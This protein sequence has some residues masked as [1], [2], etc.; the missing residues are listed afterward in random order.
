MRGGPP[1]GPPRSFSDPASTFTQSD[2]RRAVVFLVAIKVVGIIL[3]FDPSGLQAFDLPKSLLS[4]ATSVLLATALL[5]LLMRFGYSVIPRTPLH[6]AVAGFVAANLI[7]AAFAQ[8]KYI[9][10]F[11]DQNRYLGL[12]FIADMVVLYVA[13]SVAFLA[14]REWG[15]LLAAAGSAAALSAGYAAVQTLGLDPVRWALD[16]GGRPFST[17]GHPDVLGHFLSIAFGVSVG[18]ALGLRGNRA[19]LLKLGVFATALGCVA[20]AGVVATRGTLLGI[21]GAL[22]VAT[23]ILLRSHVGMRIPL[24]Q[25]TVGGLLVLGAL[26]AV[27]EFTP[28]GARTSQMFTD[29]GSGRVSLYEAAVHAALSRPIVGFGPDNFG[30]AFPAYREPPPDG[31]TDPQTSA[32]D[33]ILQAAV[34]TGV[35]GLSSLIALLAVA[36]VLLWRTAIPRA[37]AIGLPL[38]LGLAAYWTH[39]VVAVGSISVDW[40]PWLCFGSI[41]SL[42]GV[43]RPT[44]T[45]QI[46]RLLGAVVLGVGLV[47]ATLP[48]QA[49]QANRDAGLARLHWAAGDP[50]VA[51]A[52]A[53]S[54]TARDS[55]RAEYWN[56]LGLA[57]SKAGLA[58]DA[59][60]AFEEAARR[61]PHEATYWLN[62]SLARERQALNG[63][64]ADRAARFAVAAAQRAVEVDPYAP[65]VNENLADVALRMG[66]FDVALRAGV[67]TALIYDGYPT[68][69]H[70]AYVAAP[71]VSDLPG[72]RAVL[73]RAVKIR[74][75]AELHAALGRVALL[76]GDRE[77]ARASARRAL[78]LEP[79]NSEARELILEL[80]DAN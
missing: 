13:T 75:T 41:A 33:W 72:A 6:F 1:N 39:A 4:G 49:Y 22:A 52:L 7:S 32:H 53:E 43:R 68:Y 29:A 11:G 2:L 76:M 44:P 63:E 78:E 70:V 3:I 58:A 45:R 24:R 54:A 74:D 46:P 27:V 57:R 37:P 21:A 30:V 19:T 62:L 67:Q 73:E 40:F 59:A 61:A 23:A 12:S 36:G 10:I 71:R 38:A 18:T 28:I 9:A 15:A 48:V 65:R 25:V 77:G 47:A 69:A 34:T 16:F 79:D 64:D 31:L 20:A 26:W 8:N 55:G 80:G 50:S 35:L 51:V 66:D 60:T 56:W 17:F 42:A 14:P 5:L